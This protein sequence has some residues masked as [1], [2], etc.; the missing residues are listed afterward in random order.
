MRISQR[1][2]RGARVPARP[3][4]PSFFG[5]VFRLVRLNTPGRTFNATRRN[6]NARGR[7]K[8]NAWQRTFNAGGRLPHGRL[9]LP[10]IDLGR[11]GGRSDRVCVNISVVVGSY[12]V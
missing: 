9:P 7:R 1:L 6:I 12:R 8:I 10:L 5:W 11:G 2:R 3:R 4:G